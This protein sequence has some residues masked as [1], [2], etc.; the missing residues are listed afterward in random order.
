MKRK[1]AQ[2]DDLLLHN[3]NGHVDTTYFSKDQEGACTIEIVFMNEGETD[4]VS[5]GQWRTS[6][7]VTCEVTWQ[8]NNYK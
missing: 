3:K 5:N 8:H 2:G 4:D 7:S 1:I 6:E